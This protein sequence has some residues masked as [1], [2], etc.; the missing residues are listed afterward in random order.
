MKQNN[1]GLQGQK[2]KSAEKGQ[3][4]QNKK[5]TNTAGTQEGAGKERTADPQ[6]IRI[7]H[8]T[9]EAAN[10]CRLFCSMRYEG[11]WY[12]NSTFLFL[13]FFIGACIT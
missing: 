12:N 6:I 8:S 13:I 11:R 3:A 4:V 1:D 10:T 7:V 2:N 9:E 5:T